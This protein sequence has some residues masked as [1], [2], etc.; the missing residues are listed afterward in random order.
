MKKGGRYRERCAQIVSV[1]LEMFPG[2]LAVLHAI[3]AWG[4][5]R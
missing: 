2:G 3:E 1:D 4:M 5:T